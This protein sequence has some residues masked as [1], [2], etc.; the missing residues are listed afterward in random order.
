MKHDLNKRNEQ[1]EDEPDIH[2][3]DVGGLGKVVTHIDEHR[4]QDQHGCVKIFRT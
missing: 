3:L 2:H 1:V 4:C